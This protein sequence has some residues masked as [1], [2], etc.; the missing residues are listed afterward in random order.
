MDVYT[1]IID[2]LVEKTPSV[3][4]LLIAEEGL[5]SRGQGPFIS[6][7]NRFVK[8]LSKDQ[9]KALSMMLTNERRRAIGDV[10]ADLT[11]WITCHGVAL[12][13]GDEPMPVDL[14]GGGLDGDY[15]GRLEGWEWPIEEPKP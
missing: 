3:S 9:R 4:G 5:Y 13:V 1:R 14:S 2:R 8:S 10:L 7:M 11:W 15:V 6:D 12:F